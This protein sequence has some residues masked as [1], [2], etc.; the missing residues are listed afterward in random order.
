MQPHLRTSVDMLRSSAE[1]ASSSTLLAI[2]VLSVDSVRYAPRRAEQRHAWVGVAHA[3]APVVVARFVLRC[4][5]W[6]LS[7]DPAYRNAS[8]YSPSAAMRDENAT[9]GDLLC[10]DVPENAGRLKGPSLLVIAWFAHATQ[11]PPWGRSRFVA[12][13]DDDAYLHLAP[14]GLLALLHALPPGASGGTRSACDD[15][16]SASC[17]HGMHNSDLH[18]PA[19]VAAPLVYVGNIHGWSFN[20]TTFRFHNFGWD[21]CFPQTACAG[22]FPFATGSFMCVSRPLARHV[23]RATSGAELETVYALPPRHPLF[24]HDPYLG[25]A[26][27][28]LVPF[29]T[30]QALPPLHVYNLDPWSEDTDGFRIGVRLLLWHN[31]HKMPCRVQCIGDYYAS[32]QARAAR[33]ACGGGGH[34]SGDDPGGGSGGVDEAGLGVVPGGGLSGDSFTWMRTRRKGKIDMSRYVLWD[35][36]FPTGRPNKLALPSEGVLSGAAALANLTCHSMVDLRDPRTVSALNLTGCRACFD[37]LS[38]AKAE[39]KADAAAKGARTPRTG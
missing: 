37:A 38:R 8:S 29:G 10:T 2:G 19:A 13:A 26:I 36:H 30:G 22:P 5:T 3:Y 21:G 7:A 12:A 11:A 32:P 25:Q 23:V 6:A 33:R 31:R 16:T 24:F 34:G 27:Y 15:S 35:A 4:G 39:A 28:R 17:E 1:P 14:D 18:G 9:H 20:T